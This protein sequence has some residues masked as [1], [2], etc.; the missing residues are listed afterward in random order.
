[1]N[2]HT[3]HTINT[4]IKET[5]ITNCFLLF[6]IHLYEIEI[7]IYSHLLLLLRINDRIDFP[8]LCDPLSLFAT[9]YPTNSEPCQLNAIK[10]APQ[11]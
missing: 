11:V 8:S 10:C 5:M 6:I 2:K 9:L 3:K 4:I 1:M 7:N